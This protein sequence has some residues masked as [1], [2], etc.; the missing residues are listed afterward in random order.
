M[1]PYSLDL[2]QR[3]LAA[4]DAGQLSRAAIAR[5]FSVSPAWV[6]RLVQRRRETGSIAPRPR[7]HGP[8][9][10]LDAAARQDLAD[11]V[12]QQPDATLDELRRRLAV[13]V[14]A[15]TVCRALRALGLP[16]K[17]KT[18]RAAEQARPDVQRQ[19][20]EHRV[21]VSCLDPG[22]LIFVDEAA[23]TTAMARRRARAAPGVRAVADVPHGHWSVTTVVAA[24]GLGGVVAALTYPGGTDVA[25]FLAFVEEVLG[26]QLR[27]GDVVVLD[28]LSAHK[29]ACVREA[30]EARG[31]YLLL[32]PPYSPDLNPIEKAWSKVKA[33]LRTRGVRT[34]LALEYAIGE[35]LD[36][37][38]AEDCRGFFAACGIPLR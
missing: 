37:V 31:A 14:S 27:A 9:P 33:W 2:R 22:R 15:A 34:P 19:R 3:V 24:I 1:K 21:A 35:A 7:R 16:L 4:V 28:N 29:A 12:R 5:T 6:R 8:R 38:T 17:K 23:A 13:S 11:L 30:V 18:E 10:K 25:A 32:L 20:R 36:R 26:P